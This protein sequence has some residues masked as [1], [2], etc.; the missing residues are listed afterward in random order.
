MTK[1]EIRFWNKVE[2]DPLTGCLNWTAFKLP[3]GYGTINIGG[4]HRLAHRVSYQMCY[5][6]D[7]KQLLVCHKCDNPS[8][9]NPQHLFLGTH[10]DN[11][12]DMI[13]KGRRVS[14]GIN[15]HTNKTH[16]KNGHEFTEENTYHRAKN[17]KHR[18]CK[19]CQKFS[20]SKH[21]E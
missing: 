18:D 6:V 5:G 9:V 7:P 3:A 17:K 2:R 21:R 1:L 8:C 15:Q 14:S 13:R 20:R 12:Q 16:C 10:K 4:T 19:I 11:T